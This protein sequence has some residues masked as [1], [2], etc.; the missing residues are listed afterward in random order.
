MKKYIKLLAVVLIALLFVVSCGQEVSDDEA[1]Q[2]LSE[3][4]PK[5]EV[6]NE[7]FWGKGLPAV[8]SAVLDPNKKVSRQYYDVSP[9][10]PYQ[11]IAELKAAA[12]EVYSAEYMKIIAE[13]AFDGTDEFF[14]RYMEADGQL[15]VD[16]AFQGYNLRTKLRPNEAKVRRASFGLLEVAVPC[17]FDGQPSED[18]III[19]VNEN[20]V[21]KLDS[22][23]Y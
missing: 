18:Y 12:A 8:D 23:T 19:L 17:D 11:T 10:C 15:R 14:P 6:F 5:A 20:G 9:D 22:P 1:R 7:A 21:W 3:I 13:T 2:I 4:I 16:I